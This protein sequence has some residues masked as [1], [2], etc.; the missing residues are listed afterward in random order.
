MRIC[1]LLPSATEIVCA[2]GLEDSLVGVSH[3]CDYPASVRRK[4]TLIRSRVDPS[5]PAAVID[6]RVRELLAR[7]ESIYSVDRELLLGLAPDLIITQDL[8]HVC[9]TSPDDLATTLAPQPSPPSVLTLSADSLREVWN[10]IRAVGDA[11]GYRPRADKLVNDLEARVARVA[12]ICANAAKKQRVVCLEWLSPLYCAGHWVP[13]MVALAGGE[14]MLGRPGQPSYRVSWEQVL[15]ARPDTVLVMPCGYD[16]E[17]AAREFA[18]LPL[19][20]GWADLPAVRNG[21]VFA[22]DANGHFSR[23]GPRLVAGLEMIAELFWPGK[24]IS[25]AA[26][27]HAELIRS[28]V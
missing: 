1:S 25:P 19:P 5:S 21:S 4:P 7:G 17:K 8:C 18:E 15:H 26:L 27:G 22:V 14:D 11:T 12:R 3:E 13:E 16:V 6:S 24:G 20:D 28:L 10:D 9:A 23:P 2:L